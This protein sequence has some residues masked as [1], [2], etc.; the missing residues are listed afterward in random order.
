MPS[1][2]PPPPR[3]VQC[4]HCR[5]W[6]DVPAR[7]MSISCPWCYK[8]VGLDDLVVKGACWTS[9]I[10][11]CGRVVVRP[12]ATLVAP[13]IEA[14][15]GVEVHGVIEGSI[16]SGAQLYVGPR[17]RVKGQIR[18]PSI[19]VEPGGVLEGAFVQIALAR[20]QPKAGG[21]PETRAAKDVVL[22]PVVRLPEWLRLRPA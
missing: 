6:F 5:Q 2:S 18:A 19:R 17:A 11:T 20:P 7:A 16:V 1:A 3:T 15:Q 9:K 4:Y 12:R 22:K 8:R 21:G 14:S 13:L 10:Q